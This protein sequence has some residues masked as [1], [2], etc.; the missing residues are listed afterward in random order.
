MEASQKDKETFWIFYKRVHPETINDEEIRI[1]NNRWR[2]V[3][4]IDL[5]LSRW[6]G[7]KDIGIFVR[8]KRGISYSKVR[9]RLKP[10]LSQLVLEL[11]A[12]ELYLKRFPLGKNYV[13]DPF[14]PKTMSAAANWIEAQTVLYT[15]V[16]RQHL[17]G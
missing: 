16:L 7:Y 4:D 13:T 3:P 6:T 9:S 15:K 10:Y 11:H 2:Y 8:G 12:N 1:N 14:N 17:L 5:V